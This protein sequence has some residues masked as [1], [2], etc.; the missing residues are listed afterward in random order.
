MLLPTFSGSATHKDNLRAPFD[1]LLPPNED[2]ITPNDDSITPGDDSINPNDDSITLDGSHVL[3]PKELSNVPS[4]APRRWDFALKLSDAIEDKEKAS[5]DSFLFLKNSTAQSWDN[6]DAEGKISVLAD[7]LYNYFNGEGDGDNKK[8]VFRASGTDKL[9]AYTG[10][11]A[12][13]I[14]KERIKYGVLSGYLESGDFVFPKHFSQDGNKKFSLKIELAKYYCRLQEDPTS[15]QGRLTDWKCLSISGRAEYLAKVFV[16]PEFTRILEFDVNHFRQMS[17][18]KIIKLAHDAIM[19]DRV[20]EEEQ[21]NKEFIYYLESHFEVGLFT[22]FWFYKSMVVDH[23]IIRRVMLLLTLVAQLAIP[24]VILMNSIHKYEESCSSMCERGAPFVEKMAGAGVGMMYLVLSYFRFFHHSN[25]SQFHG[26]SA[27]AF[28]LTT[29][30]DRL[31][32][33]GYKE[34]VRIVNLGIL[35]V[36]TDA[37]AMIINSVALE[38][39]LDLDGIAKRLFI[40]VF[41]PNTKEMLSLAKA[42]KLPRFLVPWHCCTAWCTQHRFWNT[43]RT[44]LLIVLFC[45]TILVPFCKPNLAA[46]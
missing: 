41:P 13:D 46:R 30:I 5:S 29:F 22:L 25:P 37:R 28:Q 12:K 17:D 9:C 45:M 8:F 43:L 1:N 35:T 10:S 14:L 40:R 24:V 21:K 27:S 26:S 31:M 42:K 4:E 38:Y 33:F 19:E 39:V 34:L 15:G 20:T 7:Q 3:D 44:I 18:K 2:S 11:M 23:K 16:R 6:L 36:E 32:C